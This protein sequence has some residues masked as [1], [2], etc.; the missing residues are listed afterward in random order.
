M[1]TRTQTILLI[2]ALAAIALMVWWGST[3]KPAVKQPIAT[4]IFSCNDAKGIIGRFYTGSSTPAKSPDLPPTPGGSVALT[5]SDGRT[6]TLPQ[7]IAADGARYATP[8][9]SF[10][11]WGRGNG[12]FVLEG[13]K[14]KSYVGC[15]VVAPEPAGARLPVI[16]SNKA[17][18]FSLRLPEGY[19]ADP[20]YLFQELGPDKEIAGIK[21]TI[22]PSVATG[23]N[24][25]SDSYVSVEQIFFD[26]VPTGG[27][28]ASLF[29]DTSAKLQMVTE[30]GF[31]YSVG[32][33]VGAA[34]G[35]RYEEV[36]YAIPGTNPCIGVRYFIHYGAFENY[37]AGTVKEFNKQALV[38]EFD[39]IRHTLILAP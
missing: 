38:A 27:C 12:A 13:G 29:L 24:L 11:F 16:F 18:G 19:T 2:I 26:G 8:D 28:S 17:A 9:E 20:S 32:T 36:V 10:V 39:A 37:P 3:H 23:T 34:A 6:M 4:I 1:N 5:F 22:A 7:T 14:E 35:N 25:A 15:I 21:F 30:G 33:A 31:T